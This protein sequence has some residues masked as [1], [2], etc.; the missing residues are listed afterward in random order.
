[1]LASKYAVGNSSDMVLMLSYVYS[2]QAKP[3]GEICIDIESVLI[4]VL[5]MSIPSV[6]AV[7]N[8]V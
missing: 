5:F 7:C 6:M 3:R 2:P 4:I 8:L 1:V